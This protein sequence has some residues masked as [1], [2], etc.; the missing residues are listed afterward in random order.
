MIRLAPVALIG[1][2][3]FSPARAETVDVSRGERDFRVCAPCHSLEHDRNMTGP[4]LANV[5]GRKAGSLQSFDRYF[6][7]AEG[8][9][10]HLGRSLTRRVAERSGAHGT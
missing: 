5:W 4:S 8:F 10:D 7:R 2:A 9:G 6:R 1:L 3:L